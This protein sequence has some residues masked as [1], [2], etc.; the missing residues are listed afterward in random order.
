MEMK[1]GSERGY[2]LQDWKQTET[3]GDSHEVESVEYQK[4]GICRE[5][6]WVSRLRVPSSEWHT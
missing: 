3:A 1:S 6:Q 5:C 2:K 4:A